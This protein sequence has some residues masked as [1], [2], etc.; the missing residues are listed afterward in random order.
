[1][2]RPFRLLLALL[3]L[4]MLSSLSFAQ[5]SLSETQ[6]SQTGQAATVVVEAK[7]RRNV[8]SA[9]CIHSSGLF[10]STENFADPAGMKL[11]LNPGRE[12]Q[13]VVE[14]R[15]LRV[16]K[17]LG[18][19]L[20]QA[21]GVKDF[22]ALSLGS[23]E[24]LTELMD[25]VT[26]GF[27]FLPSE[28]DKFGYSPITARTGAITSLV[29]KRGE[30]VQVHLDRRARGGYTGGPVLDRSG[31]VVGVVIPGGENTQ[32][33]P[34]SRWYRWVHAP[35]L[36]FTSPAV[37]ASTMHRNALFAARVT[38]DLPGEKPPDLELVLDAGEEKE[39]RFPMALKDGAHRAEA[40]PVP[41]GQTSLTGAVSWAVVASRAGKEVTRLQGRLP[42]DRLPGKFGTVRPSLQPPTLEKGGMRIPLPSP[43]ADL[44]VG[45]DGRYLILHLPKLNQLAIVD[46]IQT[47]LVHQID[48]SEP[49][50]RFAAG[51]DHL[52]V[53]APKA[54]T[55][56]RWNL[57]NFEQE[58]ENRLTLKGAIH[59]I[60]L[61]S[62]S[63][64]PFLVCSG[65]EKGPGE[66]TFFD[67]G[68]LKPI[69]VTRKGDPVECNQYTRLQASADGS[70]FT[71][72]FGGPG[73]Y[74][75]VVQR[76]E[77]T[78]YR[79]TTP[80]FYAL[81]GPDGKL[82][83]TGSGLF[84]PQLKPFT[85][86]LERRYC[87]PAHHGPFYISFD[88]DYIAKSD[89]LFNLHTTEHAQTLLKANGASI[90][91]GG[92]HT[93][94]FPGEKRFHLLPEAQLLVTIPKTNSSLTLQRVDG[95]EG[96]EHFRQ[97]IDFFHVT[98][99]PPLAAL[100]GKPF[101][102]QLAV[103]SQKGGPFSYRLETSPPGMTISPAGLITWKVPRDLQEKEVSIV[104]SITDDSRR[105]RSHSFT[106][107]LRE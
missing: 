80:A 44:A 3:T 67:L 26:F 90:L 1:M 72:H 86:T 69:E 41:P 50:I 93:P 94:E 19:V 61:G 57:T 101:G 55:I 2:I 18:L 102:Y 70:L 32:V 73:W 33:L 15:V 85:G 58:H 99:R 66:L 103:R 20:L 59:S 30:L 45:G 5:K 52:V 29:R 16:D 21:E 12:E 64:G 56:T 74:S 8:G 35:V 31:K 14:G 6:L 54:A 7:V 38:G 4:V 75:L 65:E 87:F 68:T 43:A 48:L 76:T 10:L 63:V 37:T 42:I 60:A 96:L 22:P 36:E 62:S 97:L 23:D 17:E 98:S 13:K 91:M 24:S 95:R 88:Y 105:P 81:P 39:R 100:K 107:T 51:L 11:V 84:T 83:F 25:L 104:V 40:M 79:S 9:F 92:L 106:L 78:A 47:R 77:A 34:V 82:I 89:L 27:P 46:V 71:V 53:V 49:N 28:R